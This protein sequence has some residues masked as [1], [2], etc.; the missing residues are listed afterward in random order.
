MSELKV[1]GWK[2]EAGAEGKWDDDAYRVACLHGDCAL[3]ECLVPGCVGEYHAVPARRLTVTKPAVPEV[4]D[5]VRRNKPNGCYG[6]IVA[7]TDDGFWNIANLEFGYGLN[8]WE[9]DEF[10]IICKAHK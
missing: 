8:E 9:R 10:T 6:I 4:G 7:H 3:V 1:S 2:V 5:Y